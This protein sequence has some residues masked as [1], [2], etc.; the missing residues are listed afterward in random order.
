MILCL[1]SALQAEVQKGR[2][3]CSPRQP[4]NSPSKA[5]QRFH[6]QKLGMVTASSETPC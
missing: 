4:E 2:G 6:L 3:G 1:C 5:Q